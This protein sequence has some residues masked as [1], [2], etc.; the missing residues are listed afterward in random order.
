MSDIQQVVDE[1]RFIL[2]REVISQTGELSTLVKEYSRLCHEVNVRLRRC[3]DC[4][5]QGLRSEALHLAEAKPNLLDSVAILDFPERDELIEVVNLCFLQPPEPLL[6]EVASTLNAAY[7]EQEPLQ[8]LMDRHRLLAL[9]RAP[10]VQRLDVLRSLADLDPASP[11]WEADV[12]EMERARLREIE[13]ASLAAAK[14]GDAAA[15]KS[16]LNEAQ[17]AGWREAVP[18]T[19]IRDLKGRT[20]QTVK[21]AAK[22]RLGELTH[23]L[24]TAFSALDLETARPLRDEWNQHQEIAGLGKADP[25]VEQVE[26]ILGWLKD[27][28]RKRDDERAYAKVVAEVERVLDTDDVEPDV[29]QRLRRT[30]DQL[31]RR[32]PQTVEMRFRSRLNHQ[33]LSQHRRR[34]LIMLAAAS[35]VVVVVG[36]LGSIVYL[37]VEGEKSKRLVAAANT[38]LD[39]GRLN[40]A[41]SLIQQHAAKSTSEAW[42][43]VKKRLSD[44]EQAEKER[45][46]R[47]KS[48]VA[49]VQDATQTSVAEAALQRAR[50]LSKTADEKI[51]LGQLQA[52]WQKRAATELAEREVLARQAITAVT[53]ALKSLDKA[54]GATE[55]T[56]KDTIHQL[57]GN[58][59]A[60]MARLRP[61]CSAISK[62]LASQGTLLETRLNAAHQ[63]AADFTRRAILFDKLTDASL[64]LPESGKATAQAGRYEAALREFASTLPKDPRTPNMNAAADS[65]PLP[66]VFARQKLVEHWKRFAPTDKGDVESRLREIR[67][68]Q[69]DFPHA[70]DRE[71][72]TQYETWLASVLRR[73]EEDGDPD[74]GVQKR[75]SALFNS[76]LIRE[77]HVMVDNK[78]K[79][80]YVPTPLTGNLG[81]RPNIT[82]LIGFNGETTKLGFNP[83]DLLTPKSIPAPHQELAAQIRTEIRNV[84]IDG[85]QNCFRGFLDSLKNAEKVD[86]LLKYLLL[87]KTTEYAGRGD[88]LLEPELTPLRDKLS[89]TE[90][91]RSVPWMDPISPAVAEARKQALEVLS[92]LPPIEP[93]FEKAL[94]RQQRLEHDVFGLRFAVGWLDQ[95]AR[96]GWTCRTKWM[97]DGEYSLVAASRPDSNGQ[98]TWTT[99][100]KV[101][102]RSFSLDKSSAQSVGEA[103][104]VFAS[105][106]AID[107][108][109][110]KS[111]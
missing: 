109:T 107:T 72:L 54:L 43:A 92:E 76:K 67:T 50:E 59:D 82:F 77:G 5:K 97:P 74:E 60:E 94:K 81:D 41:Q 102:D 21:T 56:D 84:K 47:W 12:A 83:S 61:F 93:L 7:A 9:A 26:P 104:V 62:E 106:K 58:A 4:I 42:L 70:P 80:Y 96:D 6:V 18:A 19:L 24:H 55:S 110:T 66:A 35:A 52:T 45:V 22:R 78:Q 68:Y 44:A 17:A 75:L 48:E 100:G 30:V 79:T 25:L 10:L 49:A 91:D 101:K 64:I 87:L 85:W 29:L 89:N 32:L 71:S 23:E 63:T 34:R 108:L 1:L 31:P 51:E 13:A 111:P 65:S 8:K 37:S 39:E 103:A 40:D 2:Q 98:R 99:L 73:F 53:G 57:L 20:N 88:S 14:A 95:S 69:T 15:L 86:P 90:L 3:D 27:E 36:L 105:P 16:L 38:Y 11:H 33:E 28:D 46:A